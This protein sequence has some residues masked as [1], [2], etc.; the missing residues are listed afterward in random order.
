MSICVKCKHDLPEDAFYFSGGRRSSYCRE[1]KKQHAKY[2]NSYP[3]SPR[4]PHPRSPEEMLAYARERNARIRAFLTDYKAAHPCACGEG[5]A[6]C[7]EFH[8]RN[9]A[10]KEYTVGLMVKHSMKRILAEIAKCECVCAN[11]HAKIHGAKRAGP[12]TMP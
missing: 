5:D 12:S 9:P 10:E 8:H 2:R 3:A 6:R 1:C 11:C 7:L 4:V